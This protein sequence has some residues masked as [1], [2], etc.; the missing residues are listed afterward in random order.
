MSFVSAFRCTNCGA[1]FQDDIRE[2]VCPKCGS[3][4]EIKYDLEA[5]SK[6]MSRKLLESREPGLWKYSELLPVTVPSS[7][8]T[9]GEG[10]TYLHRCDRLAKHLGLKSLYLKDE[11]AIRMFQ[12]TDNK[13][14]S[15]ALVHEKLYQLQSLSYVDLKEQLYNL[16]MICINRGYK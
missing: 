3:Y 4:L 8:V 6:K 12:E 1:L 9:L 2:R 16:K 5:I 15:M 13:I 7:A 11:Q 10:G 14:Q